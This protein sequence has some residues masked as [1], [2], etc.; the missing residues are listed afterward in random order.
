MEE[1]RLVLVDDVITD[2]ATK[3]D[4]ITRLRDDLKARVSGLI[5]ALDRKERN[6]S[7]RSSLEDVETKT[8]VGVH[9]IVTIYDILSYLPDRT[10]DGRAAL[11][12]EGRERI[13]AYLNEFGPSE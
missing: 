9:A 12:K 10:V 6:A 5:I 4:A 3:V 1:D 7:G 8:G 13:E 2:G 11:T